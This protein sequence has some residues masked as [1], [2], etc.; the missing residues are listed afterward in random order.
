VVRVSLLYLDTA[1]LGQACPRVV[2]AQHDFIRLSADDPSMY[3][4][5]FFRD[6]SR[7]WSDRLLRDYPGFRD[8]QGIGSL[9]Q[10]V[11]QH[12]GIQAPENIFLANRS[13]QL[14]RTAARL[15]F[16][17]CRNVL[18]SDLN[19]P[20]WQA[21]VADEAARSRQRV[22][23]ASISGAVFDGHVSADEVTEQLT[24]RFIETD[25]DG[26][27]L[28]AVTNLGVRLPVTRVLSRLKASGRLRFAMIDAAQSF[29]HLQEPSP[30]KLA[31][32]TITG[33]HKWL[34]G[35]LP[36]GIAVCR[37]PLVAEQFLAILRSPDSSDLDDP[38]LRFSEEVCDHSVNGFMETVN[39]APLF[40]ANAAIRSRRTDSDELRLQGRRQMTNVEAI[41]ASANAT[42]WQVVATDESLQT[43]IVLMRSTSQT[44][45]KMDCEEVRTRF[46]KQDVALST[47]PQGLIRISAPTAQISDQ[48]VGT[49]AD[50]FERVR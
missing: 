13:I 49:L 44:V 25:C 14:I 29:C 9:K 20:H 19:W 27:F 10:Q 16:R 42:S 47:Y 40:S 11:T 21:V 5:V 35:A 24:Q 37:L 45:Q 23:L 15:M 1:R 26:L 48:S 18:T 17:N 2:Q 6:G 30:A 31:D 36:L 43:G 39:V 34:R 50:A 46:R 38:L 8:W 7:G 28:P 4:E 3:G 33:C 22:T 12:F 32:V 41:R